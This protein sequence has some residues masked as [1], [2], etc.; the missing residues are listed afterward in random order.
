MIT[1]IYCMRDLPKHH[2]NR[3]HVVPRLLGSF[4]DSPTLLDT[5][6]TECNRY[7][8]N[9]IELAFGRDSIEA[10]YRLRFGQKRAEEF[11]G[12]NGE[13]LLFRV[14][15]DM[16]GGGVV[17]TPAASPDGGD[18]VMMPPPQ[19]G[20]QLE[21][22]AGWRYHTEEELVRD[23]ARQLPSPEQKAKLRLLGD[24]ASVERIR[25]LVL[26]RLPK[27]REEGKLDLP[28]PE[29]V[30]G[31]LLVEIKSKVDRLLAR[32]VAKISFNYMTFHAG[33]HFVRNA[34][35]DAVRRFIRFDEGA[36]DWRQFV[37]FLFKPLL[38]EETEELLVTRGH[39]L[40]LGWK[41]DRTLTVTFSPYNS[42]AYEVTLTRS[43][44]GIWQ[45]PKIGHVFD[46]KHHEVIRLTPN[47]RI[48]LLPG[49]AHRAARVYQTLVRRSSE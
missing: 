27:F 24:H 5:V 8:G 26:E 14:P 43:F 2:F 21:G 9:S 23:G 36:D 47:E 33:S 11:Q 44:D 48:L 49:W 19:V 38:A 22:E 46:W 16:P 15:E 31:K 37:R 32:A 6:C 30:D 10:F 40:I 7:F 25:A 41:D 35:F 45:P 42:M 4:E 18:I 39:I 3:E 13:R 1:C 28:P 17:L 12:F 34:S 29:E 20:V